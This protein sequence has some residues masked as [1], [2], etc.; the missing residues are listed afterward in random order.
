MSIAT[1]T[2]GETATVETG[3]EQKS[4]RTDPYH[5][6]QIYLAQVWSGISES[7]IVKGDRDLGECDWAYTGRDTN[8]IC[9]Q[10]CYDDSIHYRLLESPPVTD[11]SSENAQS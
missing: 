11:D 5:D 2:A 1:Q 10:T 7:S 4:V 3:T 8:V 9:M 6:N